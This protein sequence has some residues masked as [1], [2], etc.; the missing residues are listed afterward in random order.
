MSFDRGG[1]LGVGAAIR[2]RG[3]LPQ[4]GSCA[5]LRHSRGTLPTKTSAQASAVLLD[6]PR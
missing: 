2:S 5:G 4:F 1:S 6:T 3:Q